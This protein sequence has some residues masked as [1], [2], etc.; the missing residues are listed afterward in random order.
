MVVDGAEMAP[1]Y[2]LIFRD[3]MQVHIYCEAA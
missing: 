2:D 1:T 3:G